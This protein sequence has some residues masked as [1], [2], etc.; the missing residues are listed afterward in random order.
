MNQYGASVS[1][2][3]TGSKERQLATWIFLKYY[4]SPEVQSR[5]AVMSNYF[6]VR[7][8]SA[9]TLQEYFAQDPAY[10]TA[11]NLLPYA[12]SEPPV[13]GYDFVR[14]RVEDWFHGRRPR[15]VAEIAERVRPRAT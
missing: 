2:P 1:M 10:E 8:S 6:P 9:E 5:W 15:P 7:Q 12:I 4:T 13:P 14:D 11:F 3:D